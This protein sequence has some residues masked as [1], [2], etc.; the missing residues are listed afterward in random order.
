VAG[1]TGTAVASVTTIC[2]VAAGVGVATAPYGL[3]I[4]VAALATAAIVTTCTLAANSEGNKA[5]E[6]R[7]QQADHAANIQTVS[8]GIKQSGEGVETLV[9]H[10]K[11]AQQ[12]PAAP[13]T[14]A[15][16][17]PTGT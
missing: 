12:A 3:I 14:T 13:S 9:Q 7:G 17:A 10:S 1:A 6:A 5:K 16:P 2:A 11:A 15:P 4:A 8:S